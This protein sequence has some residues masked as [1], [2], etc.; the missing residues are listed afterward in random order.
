MELKDFY[1]FLRIKLKIHLKFP[2]MNKILKLDNNT[3]KG[4]EV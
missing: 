4:G 1:A 2:M 3:D